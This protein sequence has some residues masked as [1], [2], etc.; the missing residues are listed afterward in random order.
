[1]WGHDKATQ[2]RK[3]KEERK[4]EKQWNFTLKL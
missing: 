2:L 1:M 3:E 4:C